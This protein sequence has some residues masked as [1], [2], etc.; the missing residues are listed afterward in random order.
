MAVEVNQETTQCDWHFVDHVLS[1]DTRFRL[2][3]SFQ[4]RVGGSGRPP[5]GSRA[6]R[7]AT[8]Y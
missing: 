3:R 6:N 1:K 7:E 5:G 8:V 2:G 4:T